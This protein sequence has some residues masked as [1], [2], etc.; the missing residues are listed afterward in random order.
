MWESRAIL[1]YLISS[2]GKDDA[3]YPK[4]LKVRALIDQRLH[5]DLG[6]LSQ[7]TIDYFV[8][9]KLEVISWNKNGDQ[10]CLIVLLLPFQYPTIQ[11]GAPLEEAKRARLEEALRWLD[12]FLKGKTWQA[13]EHFTVADLALCVTVSQIEAFGLPMANCPRIKQWLKQCKTFLEPYGYDVSAGGGILI[14]L[15]FFLQI[16]YLKSFKFHIYK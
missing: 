6:T 8:S 11:H 1:T 5:F 16:I 13:A 3:M 12:S 15:R 4:D 7:R 9:I 10:H 14:F 2:Y